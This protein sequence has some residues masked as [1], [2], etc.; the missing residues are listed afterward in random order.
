MAKW[1]GKVFFPTSSQAN[2]SMAQ[3]RY[4]RLPF[5]AWKPRPAQERVP[6]AAVRLDGVLTMI[7]YGLR[8]MTEARLRSLAGVLQDELDRNE[9]RW[10]PVDVG[11][12]RCGRDLIEEEQCRRRARLN[13]AERLRNWMPAPPSGVSWSQE[14]AESLR[15]G[16]AVWATQEGT[17]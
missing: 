13:P 15:S 8:V 4:P 10:V 1:S 12:I 7:E 17:P 14:D 9:K 3:G 6:V 16:W 2:R 5:D 11:R